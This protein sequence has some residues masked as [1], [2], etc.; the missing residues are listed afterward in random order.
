MHI[1]AEV[2]AL[3]RSSWLALLLTAASAYLLGSINTAIIVTG[4]Y[5]D[6]DIRHCGSGNAGATNVLRTLGKVP[7]LITALGD[8]AKSFLA[9]YLGQFIMCS[10]GSGDAEMLS[11]VGFYLAGLFCILGHLYPVYFGFRGGKGVIAL[12][13]MVL[14]LDW[15]IALISLGAFIIIVV[16]TRYVSLGA[17]VGAVMSVGLTYVFRR[18]VFSDGAATETAAFCTA[19]IGVSVLLV[20]LKHIPNIGRLFTGKESK[21]SFKESKDKIKLKRSK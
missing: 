6:Q 15:R 19:L 2:W 16:L 9:V 13:G 4:I 7:A 20:V 5:S 12:L 17:L 21:I 10:L 1:W 3:M 18:Y 8:L 14:I 11:L